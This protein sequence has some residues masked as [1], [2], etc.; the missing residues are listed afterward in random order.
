M[1]RPSDAVIAWASAIMDLHRARRPGSEV[2][3]SRG[4][5]VR[6]LI[7]LK[8]TLPQS[9]SQMF[10]RI[11]SR[12]GASNP[13]ETRGIAQGHDALRGGAVGFA[14]S[15]ALEQA[16]FDYPG[17][18][19]LTGGIDDAAD[20]ALRSNR[21]PLRGAWIDA[22]Q[23]MAVSRAALL[24]EIPPGNAVHRCENGG[25]RPEQRSERA[26]A[27]VGLLRL[28]RADHD[29]LRTKLCGVVAC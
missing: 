15:E 29:V 4:A 16:M 21:I 23:M 18:H 3:R 25:A 9:L 1:V 10:Q 2:T 24:V 20:G 28:Q 12:I 22:L 8:Q 11:V 6:A 17:R 5:R 13:A 7:G 19:D 14:D 27:G 26:R